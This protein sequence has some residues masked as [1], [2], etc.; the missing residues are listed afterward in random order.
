MPPPSWITTTPGE[1]T[2]WYT[3][4]PETIT[5]AQSSESFTLDGPAAGSCKP[6]TRRGW[7]RTSTPRQP[8]C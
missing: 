6:N 5:P 2:D 4:A 8:P 7:Y 3:L 1:S